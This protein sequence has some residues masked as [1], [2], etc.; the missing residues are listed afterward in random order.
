MFHVKHILNTLKNLKIHEILFYVFL[1]LIP[2][3]TRIIYSPM[4]AYVDWYFNYH[5]AVMVYLTDLILMVCFLAWGIF[6]RPKFH[7]K[8]LFWLI[9]AF[10]IVNLLSLFYV[11]H[12]D[13]GLYKALISLLSLILVL[14]IWV[15]FR[16]RVQFLRAFWIIFFSSIT[17][18]I[19]GLG[20]FH[21]QRGLRL[22]FL[23]EYIAPL[24]TSGLSTVSYG[25]EKLI[26][27]YGTMPH[28]NVLGGFLVFG[29]FMALFLISRETKLRQFLVSCGTVL[30]TLGIFVTFSRQA[31]LGAGIGYLGFLIY[32][33]WQ[34][35]WR[36]SL[37][38]AI[39]GLVS[40][41]TILLAGHSYLSSRVLNSDSRAVTDRVSFNQMGVEL[42]KQHPI[43]GVGVGNYVPALQNLVKLESWQ[44]QPAHNILIFTGAELGIVGLII[45]LLLI[46]EFFCRVSKAKAGTL[47]FGLVL[48]G[49]TVLILGQFDHYFVT[50]EQGRLVFWTVF[51]LMAALPNLNEA[52]NEFAGSD[53]DEAI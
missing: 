38:I 53:S 46:R 34:K 7:V 10:F 48:L 45:F 1:F 15:V 22:G 52:S 31:W 40:C 27:A 20:Q 49:A 12:L 2:I 11:K 30:I 35:E 13:L 33:V 47:R 51:G 50:I 9:L 36:K 24:G 19:I 26:R 37:I 3:Q 14:Y 29:L 39:I 16:S 18:A 42:L 4:S 41:G 23:G 6:D 8:R 21:V 28:P 25:T 5:L 32:L 17:Q 44:Y 43:L